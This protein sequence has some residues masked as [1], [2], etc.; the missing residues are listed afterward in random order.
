MFAADLY[1]NRLNLLPYFTPTELEMA[2]ARDAADFVAKLKEGIISWS[3]CQHLSPQKRY[4]LS[5]ALRAR[6]IMPEVPA[7][8]LPRPVA[9]DLFELN[10]PG[11]EDPVLV[12]G[13]SEFTLTVLTAVLATT[14]SPFY[15]LL[16]DCR[17]DTV[18]MAMVYQS[19]TPQRLV[20]ALLAHNLSERVSHRQLIIS[21]W[22]AP[23]QEELAQASGWDVLVG[24]VCA[25]E[26]PLFMRDHWQPPAGFWDQYPN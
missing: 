25:A 19:F 22:C 12:S 11:P 20:R 5:L 18:D 16:L 21:G 1:V 15:L 9:P 6:E 17:G 7:L 14:I 3:A 13:N 26:L 2:G 24:P 10:E 4:A 23:I 8:E